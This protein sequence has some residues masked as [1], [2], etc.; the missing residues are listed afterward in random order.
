MITSKEFQIALLAIFSGF[1]AWQL[2][3]GH[4]KFRWHVFAK[5]RV[6]DR[7]V[8][9][10]VYWGMIAFELVVFAA[11]ATAFVHLDR[12]MAPLQW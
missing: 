6:I 3:C 10:R 9:P 2:I 12:L 11:L 7:R 5:R 8:N 4:V 1:I